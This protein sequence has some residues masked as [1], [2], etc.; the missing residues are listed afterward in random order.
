MTTTIKLDKSEA[1]GILVTCTKCAYWFAFRF[2]QI[3]A[4]QAG[5]RHAQLVHDIPQ[6]TAA[7]AR[8]EYERRAR[9]KIR[10]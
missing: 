5:E 7:K 9:L 3:E 2:D 6:E 4:Y 1:T 10:S 8:L